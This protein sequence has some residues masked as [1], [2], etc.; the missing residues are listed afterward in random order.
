MWRDIESKVEPPLLGKCRG[1]HGKKKE[2]TWRGTKLESFKEGKNHELL[3]WYCYITS[4]ADSKRSGSEISPT[5]AVQQSQSYE[6]SQA[7]VQSGGDNRKGANNAFKRQKSSGSWSICEQRWF[8]LCLE[9]LNGRGKVLSRGRQ[10]Q[11]KSALLR[12]KNIK[13]QTSSQGATRTE[14]V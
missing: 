1:R 5:Q 10:L 12:Q 8:Y 4:I 11:H 14:G 9:V 6:P 7:I 2:G 3:A 13:S